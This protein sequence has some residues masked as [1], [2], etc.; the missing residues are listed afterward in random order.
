MHGAD[1]DH[2]SELFPPAP[3][4]PARFD[5]IA[6]TIDDVLAGNEQAIAEAIAG[7]RHAGRTPIEIALTFIDPLLVETGNRWAE[8]RVSVFEEHTITALCVRALGDLEDRVTPRRRMDTRAVVG[9]AVGERHSVG[10]TIVTIA[11]RELGWHVTSLGG[12]VPSAD[13]VD[14]VRELGPRLVALSVATAPRVPAVSALVSELARVEPRP[15]IVVGGRAALPDL[16]PE[17]DFVVGRDLP[18]ALA[19]ITQLTGNEATSME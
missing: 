10:A 9:C 5:P 14:E 18:A 2:I 12:S 11:L 1:A 3:G 8:G 7:L 16:I 17:A 6:A 13:F 19:V 4:S 15:V